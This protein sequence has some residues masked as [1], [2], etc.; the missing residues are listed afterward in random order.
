MLLAVVW[1][2]KIGIPLLEDRELCQSVYAFYD[3]GITFFYNLSS[4]FINKMTIL[5]QDSI[6]V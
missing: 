1:K 4:A 2:K 5:G 6:F 3:Q